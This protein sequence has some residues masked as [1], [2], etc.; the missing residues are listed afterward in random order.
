MLTAPVRASV[1]VAL[2]ATRNMNLAALM[3]R[4][5]TLLDGRVV[6]VQGSG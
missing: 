6:E 1:L 5:V 4:R 2:I 3:D